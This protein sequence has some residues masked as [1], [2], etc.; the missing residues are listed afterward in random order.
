MF[1]MATDRWEGHVYYGYWPVGRSCLLW[2]LTGG[3]V[4]FIMATDLWE[5]H[6]DE[7]KFTL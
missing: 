2:L 1:I 5:G 6:V 3:K 4:M 7:V